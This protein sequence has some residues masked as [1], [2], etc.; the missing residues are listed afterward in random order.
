MNFKKLNIE[1]QS[2]DLMGSSQELF[3]SIDEYEESTNF[4][5]NSKNKNE[6]LERRMFVK[7]SMIIE[8]PS[9]EGSILTNINLASQLEEM[10]KNVT[11]IIG[12]IGATGSGKSTLTS[13]FQNAPMQFKK[14]LVACMRSIILIK[15][16]NTLKSGMT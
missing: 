7:E 13:Y 3:E 4:V 6:S 9:K 15:Q 16:E 11:K 12:L 8:Q 14:S 1:S 2:I 5:T 10:S